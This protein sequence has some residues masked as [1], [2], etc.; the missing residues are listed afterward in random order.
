LV[1]G[2]HIAE[3]PVNSVYSSVVTRESI[4]IMFTIAALNDLNLLGADAQ[5]AY[6]NVN[7]KEKVYTVSREACYYCESTVQSE[8]FWCMMA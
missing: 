6:I 5:N 7:T 2:G 4:C 1:A 3:P 8:M